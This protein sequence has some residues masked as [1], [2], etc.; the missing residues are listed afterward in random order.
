MNDFIFIPATL[1]QIKD[2][3]A[4]LSLSIA[5]CDHSATDFTDP[6][7]T[8]IIHNSAEMLA[9]FS[10]NLEVIE[11]ELALGEEAADVEYLEVTPRELDTLIRI[12]SIE[13]SYQWADENKTDNPHSDLL[14]VAQYAF[15]N[16]GEFQESWY[17]AD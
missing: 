9:R 11:E 2:A 10:S 12:L 8:A 5:T 3:C 4:T 6:N 15:I 16:Q 13:L 17:D 14:E 1:G 7:H